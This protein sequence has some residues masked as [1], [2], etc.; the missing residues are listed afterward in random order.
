MPQ[1]PARR[2]ET[3]R[4]TPAEE[5]RFRAWVR[6]NQIPDLDHP[7]SHYDYR[8]FWKAS[9]GVPHPPGS[10]LHFPDTFKQHG[11][12]TFSQES[13]Y[14]SGPGD[15]GTWNGD[16]FVPAPAAPPRPAPSAAPSPPRQDLSRGGL[17]P[18]EVAQ[19]Y[20]QEHPTQFD[21]L[22]DS[23]LLSAIREID[24][25][26]YHLIDPLL[27]GAELLL[28]G[29]GG[30]GQPAAAKPPQ[31]PTVSRT[32]DTADMLLSSA[33][34]IVPAV[35]GSFVSNVPWI[36]SAIG[37]GTGASGELLGQQY[38]RLVGLRQDLNPEVAVVE[39]SLNAL[40]VASLLRNLSRMGR[41]GAAT[42]QGGVLGATSAGIRPVLEE[43]R[44]PTGG[45]VGRGAGYGALFGGATG[46][47]IEAVGAVGER[48]PSFPATDL[49]GLPGG[50]GGYG[51]PHP[52]FGP[53]RPGAPPP[54]VF[55]GGPPPPTG[56]L[57]RPLS[58]PTVGD[59]AP[60][61]A[62]AQ[63]VFDAEEQQL[64]AELV[65]TFGPGADA[66]RTGQNHATLLQVKDKLAR[67]ARI[68]DMLTPIPAVDPTLTTR[69]AGPAAP[70]QLERGDFSDPN[71]QDIV[72]AA[73]PPAETLDRLGGQLEGALSQPPGPPRLRPQR[74]LSLQPPPTVPELGV[75]RGMA[76]PDLLTPPLRNLDQ[77]IA[78]SGV[79]GGR[80]AT[81]D[82]PR[83]PGVETPGYARPYA[84]GPNAG[85]RRKGEAHG[86]P[87]TVRRR[88]Q[89]GKTFSFEQVPT[90]LPAEDPGTYPPD[91]RRELAAIAWELDQFRYERHQGGTTPRQLEAIQENLGT[92]ISS[93]VAE[94]RRSGLSSG[95]ATPGAPVYHEI[96]EAAGGTFQHATRAQMLQ[97]IRAALLEGKGTALTDAAAQVARRRMA[98][99]AEGHLG[100][101]RGRRNRPH[102]IL[103]HVGDEGD[104]LIGWM[105]PAGQQ[106]LPSQDLDEWQRAVREASDGEIL[107][108]IRIEGEG[109]HEETG[110]FFQAAREEAVRRGLREPEQPGLAMEGPGGS[111]GPSLF[112]FEGG[113]PLT[114]E[115][116]KP[117]GWGDLETPNPQEA[118]AVQER[119]RDTQAKEEAYRE[120]HGIPPDQPLTQL[121]QVE[122][123][124]GTFAERVPTGFLAEPP[125]APTPQ[126]VE[127][128]GTEGVRAQH[129][130]TPEVADLPFALSPPPD[131][132]KAA[133]ER[134]QQRR[135][136]GGL[137]DRLKGEEGVLVFNI[138]SGDRAGLKKWLKAQEADHGGEAWYSRAEQAV[139]D[140]EWDRAWKVAASASVRSYSKAYAAATPQEERALSAS[141]RGTPLQDDLN[142]GI[143]AAARDPQP[144]APGVGDF[145]PSPRITQ[146]GAARGKATL[147]PAGIV[148]PG[149]RQ[150]PLSSAAPALRGATLDRE[151]VKLILEQTS[152]EGLATIPG[153]E[154]T[155]LR[156]YRQVGEQVYQGRN[157]KT[158]REAGVS[159]P[160]EELAQHFN[161][162]IAEWARG[163]QMLQQFSVQNREVL[164]EAAEGMSMGGA[165]PG[166]IGG[167][168]PT[169]TGAGGRRIGR[170]GEIPTDRTLEVLASDSLTYQQ[171][172]L[173][174]ALQKKA[175][176]GPLRALH[177]ASYA[178]ML[179]KWN[180][181][182][183][184]YVSFTGRY[185]VDSLDHALTIPLAYLT[186]D[187]PTAQVSTAL[188]RERGVLPFTRGA[189]VPP[190]R[191][192][193][194][195]L[196]E[197]YDFTA[198][199]LS[200]LSP[201]DIRQTVRL[202]VDVPE[203]VAQYLG[204]MSGEDLSEGAFSS[205]PVLR[206]LIN[207]KVQRLLTMF[208]R[209]QEFSARGVVFDAT[210]RALLRANG[211]QPDTVLLDR[212]RPRPVAEIKGIVGPT[213]F[214]SILDTATAQA[215]EATFAGRVSRDSIPGALIRF[216]N[217]WPIFKL[218]MPFPKFNF[219]AAPRWIYD[220]S[221]AALL[222]LVRFPLD[223]AGLTSSL[224]PS[225]GSR[226]YR[227]VRAG[228]I[229]RE[230]LP[231]LALKIT[232]AERRQGTALAELVATQ[233]ELSVRSRQVNRLQ[234]RAQQGIPG[235][236][237]A[238]EAA[239]AARDQLAS[240]RGTL[241]AQMADA[242][243][244]V[245]DLKSQQKGLLTVLADARGINAPNF[246][247]YLAR[248]GTGT[249]G[250]LGAAL[251][252]RSQPGAEGTRWYEYRIPRE[253]KDPL[254]MDFRPFAPFA[255]YLFVADVL[256][257]FYRHTDWDAVHSV[258]DS[259]EEGMVAS[260]LDW[261]GA[262]WNAYEGKYTEAELGTQFAQAFLSISRAAGT[263]L[264]LVDLLTQ[265]GWPSLEDASRAVVGTIGQ[266]LSRYFVPGQQISDLI[267][268]PTGDWLPEE[269]KVR[270]PPKAT[271]QD[272]ERPLAAPLGNIP[273][274][275]Q[276]IPER[277]SQTT[278]KPVTS[279]Y[280]WLRA[281]AGIGTA[282][283]DFVTEEVR[284]VGVPGQSVFIKE[285]GDYGLDTLIADRYSTLLQQELPSVLE[286]P[287]YQALRTPARQ[288]DYL[289][290]Y[291]FPAIKRGALAEARSLVGEDQYQGALVQGEAARHKARQLRLL[292]ELKQETPEVP[293]DPDAVGAPPPAGNSGVGSPPPT[294]G[295]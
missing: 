279:E 254:V 146:A 135:A 112:D 124:T 39:G 194:D 62:A 107:A 120:V 119:A 292:D 36:G 208:N 253:G 53:A 46:G 77:P 288:R 189:A 138:P 242:R 283:R 85:P 23:E 18:S 69:P 270:I 172:M 58:V 257:D 82:Q 228:T 198:D 26:T 60:M 219:S 264:T 102:D 126:D 170:V 116:R 67:L 87:R 191:A 17:S 73:P 147:G 2:S 83:I 239:V 38:E 56:R 157:L 19:A 75:A 263:T 93:A 266:F 186:G 241:K 65:A 59:Q 238:L 106:A 118:L 103:A 177:D 32:P 269:A 43:Q 213:L 225:G 255:Q 187:Q 30:T 268:G 8:G 141:V 226:L 230:A 9:Q 15:G 57:P 63:A 132:G 247:Q 218:G 48:A 117:S 37:F 123:A 200:R 217:D 282:P 100:V 27:E 111:K 25:D 89:T 64:S 70:L 91:V 271:T 86:Q 260:P 104:D 47:A 140:G 232:G 12:P 101:A 28:P 185:G 229:E 184:N 174:N 258:V 234:A 168:P 285:T 237:T 45:E 55:L 14:S 3:T 44:Y 153:N 261:S 190:T 31:I 95:G 294:T 206:H 284:R 276:L 88:L 205:T 154:D 197:I 158:L 256:N 227:G 195:S 252:V 79:M 109:I 180:T 201:K 175:P 293:A 97:Q 169:V 251:V 183:R 212:G 156:L 41:V 243:K 78:Q 286:H 259:E 143:V 216:V 98:D 287:S 236:Q 5:G 130:P 129:V 250:M 151:V 136:Q 10:Q 161:A 221:P 134:M 13:Q 7:D 16:Q 215:L 142:T 49:G 99:R 76:E 204:T 173:A 96:R 249:V 33:A 231:E 51:Q 54:D 192:W 214:D 167:R 11:H 81:P 159:I 122:A 68:R 22:D 267:A 273:G 114:P 165:L 202:M 24:P 209:A 244:A 181:A 290:R 178:W 127:L 74:F 245:G 233:R 248:I 182:V 61:Q 155:F 108:A 272:W 295:F 275:R 66:G 20:R 72:G 80:P 179:S 1:A 34:R 162:T 149:R 278:G 144:A 94:A 246:S 113:L 280:P 105:D 166:L 281:L 84:E 164:Q 211:H 131:P 139:A 203:Q 220:H 133:L 35:A 145:P 125:P 29:K 210:T 137:F 110:P 40:P 90:A 196:Q 128:P 150:R 222:D 274:V 265:N 289:Q 148:N 160:P 176:I 193:R 262:I 52:A 21:D 50:S 291:I 188:L 163:M 207:P 71:L 92:D 199:S 121:Q 152:A 235:T 171:V 240:R 42:L 223:A 277:I 6:V 224:G 115:P 4:L